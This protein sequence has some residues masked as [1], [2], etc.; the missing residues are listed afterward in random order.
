MRRIDPLFKDTLAGK[1]WR[2]LPFFMNALSLGG[3]L[4]TAFQP[5]YGSTAWFSVCSSLLVAPIY[6]LFILHLGL[7]FLLNR[8]FSNYLAA[9]GLDL[10]LFCP[11]F[12]FSSHIAHPA[13]ILCIRQALVLLYDYLEQG[14][15]SHLT[16]AISE[17]PA[18][19]ICISFLGVIF[20]GSFLLVLPIA[21]APN[22]QASFL[23]A[24]F[25]A[26]SAVCVT[27][28]NVI[29]PGT[30]FSIF[31]QMV[32]LLLIQI[33]GL[34]IMTLSA[35]VSMLLGKRSAMSQQSVM[36]NVLDQTDLAGLKNLLRDIIF[37]TFVTEAV[38]ALVLAV[39]FSQLLAMPLAKAV[40]Y[41]AFHSVSAFCNAGFALF[42]DSMMGFAEDGIVNI[43][44]IG[45]IVSGGIGFSVM[46]VLR[47][48]VTGKYG[49]KSLD[50]HTFLVLY[51][52]VALII[53]GAV[54]ILILESSGLAF[55]HLTF[56]GKIYASLFQSVTARTAGFNTVDTSALAVP[57]A[58][59][60]IMLMFIGAS[61]GSTGGGIKTTTF[62]IMVLT[63]VSQIRGESEVNLRE[64]TVP[65]DL[66]LKAFLIAAI[67]GCLIAVYTLLLLITEGKPLT[68][69]L[70]EVVSAFATVGL[71]LNFTSQLTTWGRIIII[72]LMFIGRVG[73]LTLALSFHN[74]PRRG[75]VR[76][77]AMR[78]MVG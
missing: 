54:S 52:S 14:T 47:A 26:T 67:S 16:L 46:G 42:P 73:P 19:L 58:F 35:A 30:Y 41:G 4:L 65:M 59:I 71:S 51:T 24:L 1:T 64:R 31:G 9:S 33:G 37:W 53:L 75:D 21:L 50:N 57:T 11:L 3:P 28:L 63:L 32:V 56:K 8:R 22:Q 69:L 10:L 25:T 43:T 23:T 36:Q 48:Y 6:A 62:A 17:K 12:F 74:P 72:T 2:A 7:A 61:P 5:A 78:I 15:L 29:D 49:N 76:Y 66:V 55:Q 77:P 68:S 70:F 60:L 44:V 40:Y 39:R 34:G 45:L 27:G 13:N 38:G 18:R 20:L